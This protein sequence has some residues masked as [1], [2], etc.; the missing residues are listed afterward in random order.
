MDPGID[1]IL[2]GRALRSLDRVGGITTFGAGFPERAAPNNPLRY[3][4]TWTVDGVLRPY[5][6]AG[7]VIRDRVIVEIPETEMFA[8]E[9]FHELELEGLGTLEAFPN[10]DALTYAGLLGIPASRL[11]SL[12]SYVL[13]WPGYCALW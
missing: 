11:R 5:R 10:G 1:L 8:S 6:R 4:V 12:G 3:K 9:H 2:L 7:R 13:R